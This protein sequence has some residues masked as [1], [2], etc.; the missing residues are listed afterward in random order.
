MKRTTSLRH[1]SQV[2]SND[3]CAEHSD[4]FD[5]NPGTKNARLSLNVCV[6]ESTRL[7]AMQSQVLLERRAATRQCRLCR[8]ALRFADKAIVKVGRLVM[9]PDTV[10]NNMTVAGPMS[11]AKLMAHMQ[12]LH[13][14]VLPYKDAFEA[15]G[16]PPDML[17]NAAEGI[18]ALE[19]ARAAYAATIQNAAAARGALRENQ[20][21]ATA[22]ILA[23]EAVVP[24]TTPGNREVVKKLKVA[25]RVGPRKVQPAAASAVPASTAPEPEKDGLLPRV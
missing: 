6:T 4:T 14:R 12:A 16:L 20:N 18:T 8:W 15:A 11:D 5:T 2:R 24:P 10:M 23:L 3:V 21:L 22:T 13:D 25:R 7:L 1:E 9:L 19:A 17:T